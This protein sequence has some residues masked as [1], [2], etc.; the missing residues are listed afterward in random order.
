MPSYVLLIKLWTSSK[1]GK[2]YPSVLMTAWTYYP[3]SFATPQSAARIIDEIEQKVTE[4]KRSGTLP[5]GRAEQYDVQL[6]SL[7][8]SRVPDCQSIVFPGF[9]KLNESM[10]SLLSALRIKFEV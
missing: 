3:L 9:Y 4:M 6:E 5:P 7:R 8:D 10:L 1:D 2:G